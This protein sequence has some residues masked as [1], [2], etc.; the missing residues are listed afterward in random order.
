MS[1]EDHP[2]PSPRLG[3]VAPFHDEAEVLGPFVRELRSELVRLEEPYEVVMVDD[4]STDDG[5]S[6]L[7]EAARDWP[8]LVVVKLTRRFGK[9]A[10][11]QAG[12]RTSTAEAVVVMDADLQH[13]P[14]LIREMFRVW[15][16]S[17][18]WV[19]EAVKRGREPRSLWNRI[20]ASLF[21]RVFEALTEL[22]M[23]Q[24]SDFQLLDR[25][26][27]DHVLAMPERMTIFR[28]IVAWLGCPSRTV[29]FQVP[30]RRAGSSRW[31]TSALRTL[32]LDMLTGF[33]NAPLRIM[34][35]ASGAFVVFA[36][37]LG[38]QTLYVYLSG[39]AVEGFTTVILVVLI[40]SAAVSMGLGIIG[41][42]LARIYEEVK[43]RPT[44]VI[45][46]IRR[47]ADD[48][49]SSGQEPTGHRSR[50]GPD[51]SE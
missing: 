37:L 22:P 2:A 38:F 6:V 16:E 1:N 30:A 47:G 40:A 12:L 4:G 8:E 42:Y 17:D 46:E 23:R 24:R 5:E 28:G 21:Y 44:Y 49:R 36:S 29:T 32:A 41:E 45:Q 10:A 31:S 50:P 15:D 48:E 33:T 25:R 11:I 3:V 19:V 39:R 13:P 9:E 18:A 34:T 35:Y 43:R 27:V 26:V 14:E 20:A 7:E 51:P